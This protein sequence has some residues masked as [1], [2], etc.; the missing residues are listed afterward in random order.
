[1]NSLAIPKRADI[2]VLQ[3]YLSQLPQIDQPLKHYFAPGLYAREITLQKDSITVG[4]LHKHA[5]VNTISK[6]RVIV[7][8]E[9]GCEELVA[10]CS[11]VSQPGTKR[12][13][14][15]AEE[16]VWTTYHPTHETDLVK[17]EEEVIAKNYDEYDY[18]ISKIVERLE[19][20][21]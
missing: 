5:H 9:F 3:D 17:I 15:A 6:G 12:A 21:K 8:T 2:L 14:F 13:V 18:L 10:P 1:M 7:S 4:K 11:F 19:V 20:D 16:T